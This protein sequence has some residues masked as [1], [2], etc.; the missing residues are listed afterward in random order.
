MR[1][2]ALGDVPEAAFDVVYLGE[3][4]GAA[5]DP[6]D[7]LRTAFRALRPGGR[8]HA[9]E[10]LLPPGD[11]PPRGWGERLILAMDL[12]FGMDGSRFLGLDEAKD[13]LRAAGFVARRVRDVGGS[14]YHLRGRKPLR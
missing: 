8:L 3:V 11:R 2:L 9:M 6:R 14:L 7:P 5:D 12:D 1:A 10:G 13:A 4:L